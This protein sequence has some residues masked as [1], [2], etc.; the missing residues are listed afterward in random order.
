[1]RMQ[2]VITAGVIQLRLISRSPFNNKSNGIQNSL[3]GLTTYMRMGHRLIQ[4]YTQ[5]QQNTL[6]GYV[7]TDKTNLDAIVSATGGFVFLK[8]DII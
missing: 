7:I 5:L 6:N 3:H 2:V 4:H 8:L 1:M